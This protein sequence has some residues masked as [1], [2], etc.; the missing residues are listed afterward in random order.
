MKQN[1][2]LMNQVYKNFYALYDDSYSAK[3][4]GQEYVVLELYIEKE[5]IKTLLAVP[6]HFVDNVEKVISS[7]YPGAVV[8]HMEQ[9]VLL[10]AGKYIGGGE[11]VL[12]RASE[13][14]LKTYESFEA[15]PMD[16]LLASYSK[17]DS[18]EK[19][20]LQIM[21]SPVPASIH[22]TMRGTIEK[23]KEGAESGIRHTIK[24]I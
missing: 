21:V 22:K 7:F 24:E 4:L 2:Q 13:Y 12:N 20:S 3:Q 17:V 16:S 18:E 6:D 11:I 8:E 14:P 15:D 10:E 1:I 19:L 5:S 23:I 9:P